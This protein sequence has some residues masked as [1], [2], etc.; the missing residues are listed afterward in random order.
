MKPFLTNKGDFHKQITRIEGDQIISKDVEVAEKLSKYS[1]NAVKSLD[2]LECRDT[3]TP[4]DGLEGLIDI[5][6]KSMKTI[7]ANLLLIKKVPLNP[8][9]FSFTGTTLREMEK[10]IKAPNPKKATTYNNIP[11]KI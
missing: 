6:I 5:A 3:L 8:Q 7:Q 2:I 10:E 9:R 1:E 11:S 4:V